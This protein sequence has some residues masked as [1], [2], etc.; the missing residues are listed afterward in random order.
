MDFLKFNGYSH[1]AAKFVNVAR[2][3]HFELIRFNGF[4]G[5]ELHMDDGTKIRVGHW[6]EDVQKMI[7]A[8]KRQ[9]GEA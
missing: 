3:I 5:T 1:A 4:N 2:I 7:E 8:A 9:A 6:P